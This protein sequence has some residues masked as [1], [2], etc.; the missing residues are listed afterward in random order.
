M[1]T[2]EIDDWKFFF[3]ESYTDELHSAYVYEYCSFFV[4]D[5]RCVGQHI[6]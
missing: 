5:K 2:T 4:K 1:W 6:D 3:S